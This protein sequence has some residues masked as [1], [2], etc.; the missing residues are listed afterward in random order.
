M[1]SWSDATVRTRIVPDA[2]LQEYKGHSVLLRALALGGPVMDRIELEL[3][4]GGELLDELTALAAELGLA[5]RVNFRGSCTEDEVRAALA[6]CDVFVLPSIVASDGQMEGLP[7]ALM[8]ALACGAPTV[9]TRL[10]GIPE[11][12]V[13]GVTGFLAEPGDPTSLRD[14][15]TSALTASGAEQRSAA[16]RNLVEDEFELSKCV[17]EL[18]EKLDSLAR[19]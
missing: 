14:A 7:V 5:D 17:E 2:S 12:I 19:A 11:L 10:S 18:G 13:D 16:G 8:E 3:I 4:G 9:S 6:A 15:M 1:Y